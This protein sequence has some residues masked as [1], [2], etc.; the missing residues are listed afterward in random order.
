MSGAIGSFDTTDHT[1]SLLR[2]LDAG[3]RARKARQDMAVDTAIRQGVGTM[4][5]RGGSAGYQDPAQNQ[6]S[7]WPGAGTS[8]LSPPTADVSPPPAAQKPAPAPMAPNP[9]AG[10]VASFESGGNPAAVNAGGYSGLYQFGTGLMKDAG[11]Y[12]PAAGEDLTKNQ[13]AGTI[14]LPL[15]GQMTREQFLANPAAQHEARAIAEQHLGGQA[16]TLGL[17][18]YIGQNVGGVN[19]TP[20]ALVN[21]QW[22]GGSGGTQ[23]FLQSGGAYNPADANGTTISSYA[24]RTSGGG[25]TA[26]PSPGTPPM[27]PGGYVGQ[28]GGSSLYGPPNPNYNARY[29][30]I[31]SQLSQTPGGGAASLDILKNQS[32]YDMA[33]GRRQDGYARLAMMAAARGD[34]P[35]ATY[36]AQTA[37]LNVPQGFGQ[38]A[39]MTRRLGVASLMAER[40]AGGDTAWASRFTHAYIQSGDA[41]VA[42]QQAGQP[43]DRILTPKMLYD[44]STDTMRMVGVTRQ[45][46]GVQITDQGTGAP[47]TGDRPPQNRVVQT[48]QGIAVVNPNAATPTATPV[49][50]PGAAGGAAPTQ[51]QPP[52]RAGTGAAQAKYDFALKSGMTPEQ[53]AAVAAGIKPNGVTSVNMLRYRQARMGAKSLEGIADT[54]ATW[55]KKIDAEMDALFTPAWRQAIPGGQGAPPAAGAPPMAPGSSFRDPKDL[56]RAPVD[57]GTPPPPAAAPPPP[58]AKL[59]PEGSFINQNGKRYQIRGGQ[60]VEVG[61]AGPAA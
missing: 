20:E 43:R 57:T 16:N 46:E 50:Q 45:G 59:P 49:M 2:G 52:P 61:A 26:T 30:P 54:D 40:L 4:L 31:L 28:A 36:F 44:A 18:K 23:K 17:N 42:M 10:R 29:D 21:M 53:A 37:G 39:A 1:D 19:I 51:A 33:M 48:S 13:W 32:R 34:V 47:V 3:M 11:M 27:M 24:Q 60:P 56:P 38:D 8:M 9:N 58:G 25:Q 6:T 41:N 15:A 55:N 35:T 7:M 5:D 12:A 14:N 22:I